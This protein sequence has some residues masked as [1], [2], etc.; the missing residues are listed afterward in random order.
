MLKTFRD[1][2][3][4]RHTNDEDDDNGEGNNTDENGNI[5]VCE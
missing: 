3:Y 2:L 1:N 5:N 4:K